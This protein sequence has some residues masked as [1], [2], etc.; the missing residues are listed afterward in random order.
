LGIVIGISA[1]MIIMSIGGSAQQLIL[2][3]IQ[4][5]GPENIFVNPGKNTGGAFDISSAIL[6]RS[7]TN[8][9]FEDLSKKSN[10][11]DAILINPSVNGSATVSY[12]SEAK[13]VSIWGTGSDGF[14]IYT[15]IPEQ[16]RIFTQEEVNEKAAVVVLG[17]K[18]AEEFFGS[19]DSIGEKIKI[20]D[21][22]FRVIGIFSS[23]LSS[24]FGVEDLVVIPYTSAQQYLMGIKYFQEVVIKVG[25]TEAV[26]STVRDIELL[27]RDNH[28]IEDSN[29]DDFIITTQEDMI[30]MVGSIMGAITVFLSLVAAISLIVGGVGVMNIMFVSVT[31]RTREI[32]LRKALGATNKNILSQFLLESVILTGL[33]GIIGIIGG[34]VITFL[35]TAVA[36]IFLGTSFPYSFSGLGAILGILVSGGTGLLFGVFPARQASKKSP[37]EALRYE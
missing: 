10:L 16:G 2:N 27:L 29:N 13:T 6:S 28:K 9:D 32:G 12:G 31:E 24:M 26:P 18:I 22:T 36:G 3:E 25:S 1:I 35:I 19:Q 14:A 8:K 21:K 34:V 30:E 7:L 15:L 33:G 17:K 37:M 20:K 4:M 5:F 23:K 11:P